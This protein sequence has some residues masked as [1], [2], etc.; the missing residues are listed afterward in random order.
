MLRFLP[1]LIGLAAIASLPLWSANPY[2]VHL[3]T[4]IGCYWVLIAGLNLVVGFTGQL[5]VGHVGLLAIGAYAFAILAGRIGFEPFAALVAAGGLGGISGLLLGLPSLRLPGF[6]FAMATLAFALI[7]GEISL[8]ASALTGG[9]A[10]LAVPAFPAPF[11]NAAGFYWLVAMVAAGVTLLSW[12]VARMMWGRAMIALRDSEIAAAAFGVS[13]FRVKLV[14]FAA[15]GVTAGLGGA[16]F[17]ALQ[18]YITPDTFV[19]DLGLLFFV[20]IVIGGRGGILGPFLG[21]VVLVALPELV[22]PLAQLGTVFYGVLLLLVVQLMPEGI[23]SL[24]VRLGMRPRLE[25]GPAET[26]RIVPDAAS[27][28]APG[29]PCEA[30]ETLRAH[31]LGK[32]F[33]GVTA[34]DDVSLELRSAE[35]HG[36]IGPNG[37]GKTT[38]LNLLSGFYQ[39]DQGSL[40]L[41]T[42]DLRG[43]PGQ[44]RAAL[45]IA[46]SFQTP[47]LLPSLSVRDNAMLGG[48]SATRAGFLA[49]ALALPRAR[50]EERALRAD[51]GMALRAVGLAAIHD[52]RAALLG[53]AEQ[54]FLEIARALVLRP[55]FLLLDEPAG[56]LTPEEIMALAD[57]LS[58]LR[59]TGIGVLVVEHHTDF[60]FRISDRV[61]ALHLGRVLASDRP[62]EVRAAPEVIRVYLGA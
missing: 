51:A 26:R 36:L 10:G 59:E 8:A 28:H 61:T 23:G 7:V 2:Q 47:R 21:T 32:H 35:I 5:S 13:P 54:R 37:S 27:W 24:L 41:G 30:G 39:A 1:G 43:L 12:N 20:C 46:R 25:P 16:L 58:A 53:H 42:Q 40:H 4:L 60:V 17:A 9:G 14:V 18:S 31:R 44:A 56:G 50:E 11:A 45:G 55:R 52:R 6:Y 33:G 62:A 57:L 19:F 22:A 48:W 38:L 3:A 49:T 29:S 34:L 15:S